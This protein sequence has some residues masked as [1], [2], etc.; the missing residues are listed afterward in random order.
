MSLTLRTAVLVILFS[1]L[2]ASE[3]KVEGRAAARRFISQR[4]MFSMAV[5]VGWGV[6]TGLDTPVFFYAPSSERFVQD[7]I[8]P[9][10]A[11]ITVGSHDTASGQR[12]SATT[13]EAWAR[14]DTRALASSI[15]AVEPFEFPKESEVS[16]A[17]ISS[18]DEPTFSPDERQQHSV[19]VFWAYDRHMFFAHLNYNAGDPNAAKFEN[20]FLQTLR[21]VRPLQKH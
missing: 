19:A 21:S 2:A 14:V 8:P 12:K 5:P 6:S 15:P 16:D 20:V 17:V 3:G 7:R 13:P 9:G 10:G 18:Y 1:A 11:V 4:Y